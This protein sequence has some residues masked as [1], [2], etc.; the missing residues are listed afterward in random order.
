MAEEGKITQAETD[1][2]LASFS[3]ALGSNSTLAISLAMC[4][5]PGFSASYISPLGSATPGSAGNVRGGVWADGGG[6]G[7]R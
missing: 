7:A 6:G 2:G 1:H 5:G 4:S 3:R